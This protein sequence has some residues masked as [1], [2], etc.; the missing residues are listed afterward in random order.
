MSLNANTYEKHTCFLV[1]IVYYN[2]L[3]KVAKTFQLLA[4]FILKVTPF[5]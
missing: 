4:L 2:L 3:K 5:L 1:L